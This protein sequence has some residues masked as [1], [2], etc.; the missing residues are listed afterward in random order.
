MRR[1]PDQDDAGRMCA[2]RECEPAKILV[3]RQQ[4][5]ILG[6]GQLHYCLIDGALLKLTH[7]K[8]IV[9]VSAETTNHREVTA[10]V[11]KKS[12]ETDGLVNGG[13]KDGFVAY[14]VGCIGQGCPYIFCCQ[15]GIGVQ[16]VL[17]GCPFRQLAQEQLDGDASPTNHWF[18]EHDRR[19]Y[20]DPFHGRRKAILT[21]PQ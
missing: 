20:L 13:R 8:H 6:F 19:I 7:G 17:D 15:P 16:Q 1:E 12:H 5:S 2:C 3:F 14:G 9:A 11:C 10:F 21:R 18:A 4:D